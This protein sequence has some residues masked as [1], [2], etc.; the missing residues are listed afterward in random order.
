MPDEGGM[1]LTQ[2][3]LAVLAAAV[4]VLGC[5]PE[6]FVGKILFAISCVAQ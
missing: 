2:I 3:V 4:V 5:A 1:I 6:M